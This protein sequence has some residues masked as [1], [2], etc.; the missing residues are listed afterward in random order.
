MTELHLPICATFFSLLLC[1]VFFVKK[2]LWL[3]ENK[4]YAVMLITG[5]LDSLIV[6]IERIL[7]VNGDINSVTPLTNLIL[8][9]TNKLD[10]VV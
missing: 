7:V 3:T 2:R 4:I 5:F 6:T 9:L 8:Q 1:I 10:F